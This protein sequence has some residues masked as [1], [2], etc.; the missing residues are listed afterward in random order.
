VYLYLDFVLKVSESGII[1]NRA[2]ELESGSSV[3]FRQAAVI[4][5]NYVI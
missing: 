4:W 5:L 3:N 2:L 1:R